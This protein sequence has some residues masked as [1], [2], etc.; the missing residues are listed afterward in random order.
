MLARGPDW[1][2][3]SA[4]LLLLLFTAKYVELYRLQS[5]LKQDHRDNFPV[6]LALVAIWKCCR[7][8]LTVCHLQPKHNTINNV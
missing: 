3:V 4:A 6:N 2:R 1:Q 7:K 5:D 8:H